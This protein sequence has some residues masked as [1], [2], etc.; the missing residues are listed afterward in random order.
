[1]NWEDSDWLDA[2]DGATAGCWPRLLCVVKRGGVKG[3]C[4]R[5]S[6]SVLARHW[7]VTRDIVTS[8]EEAA[9]AH[10]ALEIDD[11]DWVVT[12]WTEYQEADPGA[13]ERK[14]KQ[15]TRDRKNKDVSASRLVTRDSRDRRRDLSRATETETE[16][17]TCTSPSPQKRGEIG[18]QVNALWRELGLETPRVYDWHHGAAK[19]SALTANFSDDEILA[20]VRRIADTPKLRAWA[21][22]RG[23][24][25]LAEWVNGQLV[26]ETVQKWRDED[27]SA[28]GKE[29]PEQRVDRLMAELETDETDDADAG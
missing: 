17:K 10:G 11:G 20:A 6:H 16:T 12:N 8:L 28:P 4:K 1:M 9:I 2:L 18:N 25:Y 3:R 27:D 22:R 19:L 13:T 5:P 15:R 24:S 21:G 26:L 29:T 14:R 7:R 23:P